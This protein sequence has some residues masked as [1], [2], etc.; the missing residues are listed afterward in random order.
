M[1]TVTLRMLL[2]SVWPEK[3]IYVG[4]TLK[5]SHFADTPLPYPSNK[6]YFIHILT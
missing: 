5:F 3:S 6:N 2:Y 4:V 1:G